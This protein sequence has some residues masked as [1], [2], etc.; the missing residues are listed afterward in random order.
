[1]KET[2]RLQENNVNSFNE[3]LSTSVITVRPVVFED[4]ISI[5]VEQTHDRTERPVAILH[6]T[7]A[8]DDSQLCREAD[9]LNVDDEVLRKRMENPLLFMTRI[10]NR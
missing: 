1:M 6:T 3:G 8:Q 9:T 10:M 4:K 5:N 2:S 7:A